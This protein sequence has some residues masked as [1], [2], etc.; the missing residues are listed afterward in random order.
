MPVMPV[1][2]GGIGRVGAAE[3]FFALEPPVVRSVLELL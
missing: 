2:W 1:M 3:P